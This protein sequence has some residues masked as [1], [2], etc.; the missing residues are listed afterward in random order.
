MFPM[1]VIVS[2]IGTP[3]YGISKYLVDIIQPTLNKNQHKV[4]NSKSFVSQAQ[5]WKIEPDE[6]QVYMM[7]QTFIHQYPSIKQLM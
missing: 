4:K 3:P 7:S 2:T 1:R 5:T 6:I